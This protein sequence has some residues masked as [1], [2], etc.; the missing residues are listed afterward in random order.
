MSNCLNNITPLTV[1]VSFRQEKQSQN[2]LWQISP[3]PDAKAADYE[4]DIE[5]WAK[6]YHNVVF[7]AFDSVRTPAD[8]LEKELPKTA[9]PFPTYEQL[10][11][12][13]PRNLH[14][15]HMS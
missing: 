6:Y 13:L 3:L 1:F 9:W 2:I 14:L 4:D 11:F 12:E 7:A 10:L 15:L 5:A 8:E